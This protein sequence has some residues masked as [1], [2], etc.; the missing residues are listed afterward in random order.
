MVRCSPFWR[1]EFDKWVPISGSHPVPDVKSVKSTRLIHLLVVFR[2]R[3]ASNRMRECRCK[4]LN[5]RMYVIAHMNP[6]VRNM[7]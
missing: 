1:L 2:E 3:R 7:L 5:A 4:T 6:F